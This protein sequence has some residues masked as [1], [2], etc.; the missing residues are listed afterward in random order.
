[1]A[2][3]LFNLSL[4]DKICPSSLI[5]SRMKCLYPSYLRNY[6]ILSNFAAAIKQ[7]N[8]EYEKKDNLCDA[9]GNALNGQCHSRD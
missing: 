7:K 1:M 5:L 9:D 3:P 2:A 6:F 8:K 4:F